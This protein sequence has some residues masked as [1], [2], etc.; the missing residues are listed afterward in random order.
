MQ[1]SQNGI[2]FIQNAEGFVNHAYPDANGFSIGY[3]TFYATLAAG[4]GAFFFGAV[5]HERK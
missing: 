1:T 4:L 5:R 3:G 2:I